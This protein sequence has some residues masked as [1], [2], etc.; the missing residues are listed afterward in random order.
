MANKII[1]IEE[2][3]LWLYP[4][5]YDYYQRKRQL[6]QNDQLQH[7]ATTIREEIARLECELSFLAGKLDSIRDE[8]EKE[9][10]SAKYLSLA[11]KANLLK[12]KLK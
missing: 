5:G 10:L 3:R 4:G 6:E 12:A 2:Q 1:R 7:T 11:K 8:G 9:T